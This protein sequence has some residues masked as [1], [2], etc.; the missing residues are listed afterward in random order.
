MNAWLITWEYALQRKTKLDKIVAILTS[1]KSE[2]TVADFME[3]LYLRSTCN[4]SEMAYYANHRKQ[5]PFHV[6]K[7]LLINHIPHGDRIICGG[8]P[9]W[10]YARRVRNLKIR[11]DKKNQKEILT[12]VEPPTYKWQDE[13]RSEFAIESEGESREWTRNHASR[14]SKDVW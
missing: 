4:A 3:L 11:L 7:P 1:R 10:L 5:M 9:C 2:E 6:E 14:L 12:W 8:T 13:R